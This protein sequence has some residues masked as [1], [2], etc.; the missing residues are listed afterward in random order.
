MHNVARVRAN[1]WGQVRLGASTA[2][3]CGRDHG[4]RQRG[5]GYELAETRAHG[6]L[7]WVQSRGE[8]VLAWYAQTSIKEHR[9]AVAR[10][11]ACNR[12]WP[13][14]FGNSGLAHRLDSVARGVA[15]WSTAR[16]GRAWTEGLIFGP[17]TWILRG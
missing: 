6:R 12:S 17:S 1:S 4:E 2:S 13:Y 5:E 7:P 10:T 16:R 3:R 8:I 15:G 14:P 11:T 9:E